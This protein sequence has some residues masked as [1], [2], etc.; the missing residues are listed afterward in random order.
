MKAVLWEEGAIADLQEIFDFILIDSPQNALLVDTR[1][2]DQTDELKMFPMR[3]RRGRV[4]GTRELVI[5]KTPYIA[6]YRVEEDTLRILAVVHGA[7]RWP[8]KL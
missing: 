3:G 8:K 7:Q 5:L 4:E 2:C 1:I 6:A